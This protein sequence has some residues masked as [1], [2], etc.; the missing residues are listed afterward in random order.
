MCLQYRK[1]QRT[2]F[3]DVEHETRTDFLIFSS[4]GI[5]EQTPS[6][7]SSHMPPSDAETYV[8][9]FSRFGTDDKHAS[10]LISSTPTSWKLNNE[11]VY[12]SRLDHVKF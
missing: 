6:S 10:H 5:L 2:K 11:D 3:P 9:F 7:S 4:S 8:T 1:T 12:P